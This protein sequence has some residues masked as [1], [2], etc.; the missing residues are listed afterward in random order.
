[1]SGPSPRT[2]SM[3]RSASPRRM[4]TSSS[5]RAGSRARARPGYRPTTTRA[6][7]AEVDPIRMYASS[8]TTT[9]QSSG[10]WVSAARRRA[11]ATSPSRTG[12]RTEV[13]SNLR[14]RY[15]RISTRPTDLAAGSAILRRQGWPCQ[16]RELHG[17]V[18]AG[19]GPSSVRTTGER[20]STLAARQGCEQR[21][22]ANRERR[23]GP[24]SR[25]LSIEV[26]RPS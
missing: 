1:M 5:R 26:L 13:P 2:S 15:S 12:N 18:P 9:T 22:V 17:A 10:R 21:R 3:K 4:K 20:T 19:I 6:S 14:T 23:E 25:A 16:E 7:T 11:W 24:A 8:V